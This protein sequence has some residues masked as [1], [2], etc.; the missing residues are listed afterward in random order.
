MPPVLSG[1]FD[2]EN[3]QPIDIRVHVAIMGQ[4]H[5]QVK[6]FPPGTQITDVQIEAPGVENGP[7]FPIPGP[8]G[9]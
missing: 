6:D 5:G 4:I 1:E 8:G 3:L 9:P 7:D 2:V